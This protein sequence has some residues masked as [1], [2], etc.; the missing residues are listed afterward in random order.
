[1]GGVTGE[2]TDNPIVFVG[3]TNHKNYLNL[4][5]TKKI[6]H[7][8]ATSYTITHADNHPYMSSRKRF[9]SYDDVLPWSPAKARRYMS[10]SVI[11]S[12]PS[13]K[14]V[15]VRPTA[16]TAS[17]RRRRST[18]R[19]INQ[20]T[21]GFVGAAGDYKYVDTAFASYEADTT[22][23][24]T[25]ISVVPQGTSVNERDGK[26]FRCT[27]IQVRGHYTNGTTA[28]GNHVVVLYVW[29]KQPNKALAA[30]TDV[31]DSVKSTA[32]NKRENA[33]RFVI[34]RRYDE[35]LTGPWGG[36]TGYDGFMKPFNHYIKLPSDC[37]ATCTTAD[38]TGA[39]GNRISGALLQITLGDNAPGNNAAYLVNTIRTNFVDV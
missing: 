27:S 12:L 33:S 1:M 28:G 21:S 6:Q 8:R 20:R 32:Q 18:R 26:A 19:G 14:M 17:V 3:N 5:P 16:Y 13:G 30:I 29:D 35:I 10:P 34:I 38:A 25:H 11:A 7:F 23:T 9:G 36:A 31:L 2:A 4:R 22:G 15:G 24:V 37:V 39:I